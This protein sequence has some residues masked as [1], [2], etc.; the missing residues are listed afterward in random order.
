M[1]ARRFQSAAC[2][3]ALALA[4]IGAGA[5]CSRQDVNV[6]DETE[7]RA[8][9]RAQNYLDQGR[10]EDALSAFH[11]VIDAREDAPESHL[12]AGHLYLRRMNDPIRAIYHLQRY[13]AYKPQSKEAPQV[14]QL[15]DSAKKEF[16]RQLPAEPYEGD[17]E[18]IDLME[19]VESL[20]KENLELKRDLMAAKR[21]LEDA[22]QSTAAASASS[23]DG[24]A[25][26]DASDAGPSTP[27]PE[28]VPRTHTVQPGDTLSGISRQYYGTD[29]RWMDIYQANRDRLGSQD[30]I[31]VGQEL[32]IP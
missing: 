23:G 1:A 16:A 9:Q 26:E 13:L 24:G 31:Q 10:Y 22:R 18:R 6:V 30:S 29:S 14:R 3:G 25:S 11:R 7:T 8:Y 12:E 4:A 19:L 20:R 27:D 15:I 32:R 28:D 2:L 5:G 21:K 17:L